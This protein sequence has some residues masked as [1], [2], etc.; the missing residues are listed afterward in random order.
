MFLTTPGLG[1]KLGIGVGIGIGIET[2]KRLDSDFHRNDTF[3]SVCDARRCILGTQY[4]DSHRIPVQ[5]EHDFDQHS[6]TI[7]RTLN[8]QAYLFLLSLQMLS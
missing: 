2:Q 4:G 8:S 5:T 3:H 1:G 7:G 6:T